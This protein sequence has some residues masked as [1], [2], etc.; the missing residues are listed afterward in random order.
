[1]CVTCTSAS[2]RTSCLQMLLKIDARKS[3]CKFHRKTL[4]LEFLLNKYTGLQASNFIKKSP[5]TGIFL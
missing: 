3:F 2:L 5:N 1:M 4:V